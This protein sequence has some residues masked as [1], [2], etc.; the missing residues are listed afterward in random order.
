MY[1]LTLQDALGIYL[2]VGG[3][4]GMWMSWRAFCAGKTNG[5]IVEVSIVMC[6]IGPILLAVSL[7]WSCFRRIMG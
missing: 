6:S 1:A 3:L 2:I 7:L 4:L 5:E